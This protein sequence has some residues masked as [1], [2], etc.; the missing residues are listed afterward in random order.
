MSRHFISSIKPPFSALE[1][2]ASRT[3][4]DMMAVLG[5][6]EVNTL[7]AL[8]FSPLDI[9]FWRRCLIVLPHLIPPIFYKTLELI[10]EFSRDFIFLVLNISQ[11]F[12]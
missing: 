3:L 10:L 7:P 8:L 4:T 12:F 1:Y 6:T 9:A 5:E 2:R 11:G